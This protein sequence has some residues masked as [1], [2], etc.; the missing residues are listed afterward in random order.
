[1]ARK[2]K[3]QPHM[4]AEKTKLLGGMGRGSTYKDIQRRAIVLG[5]AFPDVVNSD[6]NGLLSFIHK[7]NNRVDPSLIDKFDDWMDQHLEAIG[8]DAN[9]PIRSSKLRLGYLGEEKDGKRAKKRVPGIKKPKEKKPPKE[10]DEFNL[11]KGTKKSYTFELTQ[12][13]YDIDRVTRRVKKKFPDAN[14]KS[15]RLWFGSARRA[16]KNK[17]NGKA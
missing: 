15:I 12:R 14:D 13:G 4:S 8:Y 1:M 17:D 5:M 3:E 9:D 16:I 11:W 7:S 2:K 6:I 10:R